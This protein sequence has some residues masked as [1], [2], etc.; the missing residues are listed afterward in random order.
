MAYS[1]HMPTRKIGTFRVLPSGGQETNILQPQHHVASGLAMGIS[2]G[3]R[4]KVLF[5]DFGGT[6]YAAICAHLLGVLTSEF[7][8]LGATAV[9]KPRR[10]WLSRLRTSFNLW[11]GGLPWRGLFGRLRFSTE[12]LQRADLLFAIDRRTEEQLRRYADDHHKRLIRLIRL[13]RLTDWPSYRM[14]IHTSELTST[15]FSDLESRL[16]LLLDAGL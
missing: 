12:L 6:P 15:A 1:H 13:I 11:R 2:R 9:G 4:I 8:I 5:V 16:R 7:E 3:G 10:P 14:P